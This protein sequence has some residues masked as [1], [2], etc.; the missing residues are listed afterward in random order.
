MP[1]KQT[2]EIVPFPLFRR[3]LLVLNPEGLNEQEFTRLAKEKSRYEKRLM[4]A[5]KYSETAVPRCYFIQ[6]SIREIT[7]IYLHEKKTVDDVQELLNTTQLL[8]HSA[9]H[10]YTLI[11]SGEAEKNPSAAFVLQLDDF[12]QRTYG[13][14]NNKHTRTVKCCT[15]L[16]VLGDAVLCILGKNRR[17][18][19]VKA[20]KEMLQQMITYISVEE[21]LENPDPIQATGEPAEATKLFA[22]RKEEYALRKVEL[23]KNFEWQPRKYDLSTLR[24][25]K[26]YEQL[27]FRL[28]RIQ[29]LLAAYFKYFDRPVVRNGE[30]IWNYEMVMLAKELDYTEMDCVE[31]INMDDDDVIFF[32]AYALSFKRLDKAER[33]L[34]IAEL[35]RVLQKTPKGLKI[36]QELGGDINHCIGNIVGMDNESIK[37]IR[38]FGQFGLQYLKGNPTDKEIMQALQREG[39]L[40]EATKQTLTV[41]I[42]PD[43][44]QV[45]ATGRTVTVA[46]QNTTHH[47]T[48]FAAV[49]Q[50]KKVVVT[51]RDQNTGASIVATFPLESES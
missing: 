21:Y 26:L 46:F 5:G 51:F 10:R 22:Q 8:V 11:S 42:D 18:L 33:Y 31:A 36:K 7:E 3:F 2:A 45:E 40:P 1:K 23:R 15:Q 17:L 34:L 49:Q 12:D 38:R 16:P 24:L 6:P 44:L 25:C 48:F 29:I 50:G 43:G 35:E 47:L 14:N 37:K 19:P 30:V 4:L 39:L 20:A 28:E 9:G 27:S 32:L 41:P 13:S